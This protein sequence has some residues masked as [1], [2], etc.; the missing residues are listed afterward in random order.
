MTLRSVP[1]IIRSGESS[2]PID[3]PSIERLVLRDDRPVVEPRRGPI[4]RRVGEA[5]PLLFV[6]QQRDRVFRHPLHVPY[7]GEVPG[8]AVLDDLRS[9]SP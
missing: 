5:L 2:I 3:Q 6:F 9:L 1:A 7:R 8:Q 4:A